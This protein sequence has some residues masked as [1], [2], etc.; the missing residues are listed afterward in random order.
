LISQIVTCD[1]SENNEEC[2]DKIAD[3][4]FFYKNWADILYQ[5]YKQLLLKYKEAENAGNETCLKSMAHLNTTHEQEVKILNLQYDQLVETS[6]QNRSK[7]E[8]VDDGERKSSDLNAEGKVE[9]TTTMNEND[10]SRTMKT[11]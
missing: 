2:S 10:K 8:N 11:F 9:V 3:L 4:K 1:N 7:P 5:K 6:K